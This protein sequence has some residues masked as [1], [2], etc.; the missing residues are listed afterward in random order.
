MTTTDDRLSFIP[1]EVFTFHNPETGQKR[2]WNVTAMFEYARRFPMQIQRV[3][4]DIEPRIVEVCR[5]KRGVEQW[6]LHRLR[7]PYLSFPIVM[8]ELESRTHLM[9]DGYVRRSEIGYTSIQ[10]YLFSLG[11][12][13]PFLIPTATAQGG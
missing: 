7:D 3:T 8:A 2:S 10:A 11:Q 6:K 13:E 1:F 4:L 5:T 9:V 12:W